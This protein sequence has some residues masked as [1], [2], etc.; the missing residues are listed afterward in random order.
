MG[1]VLDLPLIGAGGEPVDFKRTLA[2]HGV[3]ALPPSRIDEQAWTLEVTLPVAAGA[4]TVRLTEGRRREAQVEILGRTPGERAREAIV[5]TLRHMFRLDEDL[6]AFYKAAAEDPDLGWVT[7]G[8]GRM[9]RSP[10]VFED[11]VKTDCTPAT[12]GNE[13]GSSEGAVPA[14]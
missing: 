10:T 2:S 11:V 12:P 7:T 9:L 8:A 13:S 3:A 1:L 4:R 6:S 5:G 14:R